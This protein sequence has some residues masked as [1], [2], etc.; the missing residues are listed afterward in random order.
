MIPK[1][2]AVESWISQYSNLFALLFNEVSTLYSLTKMVD[3]ESA[4][5]DSEKG[6]ISD[7]HYLTLN[8]LIE[9]REKRLQMAVVLRTAGEYMEK[10]SWEDFEFVPPVDLTNKVT[11]AGFLFFLDFLCLAL[12]HAILRDQ[13]LPNTIPVLSELVVAHKAFDDFLH[14]LLAGE[15]SLIEPKTRWPVL[16]FGLFDG[17]IP[18]IYAISG[19]WREALSVST[20]K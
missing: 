14:S 2:T 17:Y 3:T 13:R 16:I 5:F 15:E 6:D 18:P 4:E 1:S 9:D 12:A 7:S 10:F 8:R 19:V 20:K 11:R